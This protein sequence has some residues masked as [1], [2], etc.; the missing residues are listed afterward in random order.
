MLPFVIEENKWRIASDPECYV[1][2]EAR[3]VKG[4]LKW[5]AEG[6]YVTLADA[7]EGCLRKSVRQSREDL[8]LALREAIERVSTAADRLRQGLTVRVVVPD[9]SG[10]IEPQLLLF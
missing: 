1:L 8:P 9:R 10:N 4:K 6:Y 7:L 5:G 3:T 2:Q